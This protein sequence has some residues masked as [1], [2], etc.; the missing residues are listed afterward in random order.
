MQPI[1]NVYFD[2][3]ATTPLKE[4]VVVV[5]HKALLEDYGNPSSTH[6]FGRKVKSKI[7]QARKNIAHYLNADASEIIFTSGATE[8]DNL[9]LRS[10]VV[11]LNVQHI[12][13][14]K[15]E[16]HA[17]LH[18]IE[19]LVAKVQVTAHFL[20]V[21]SKGEP[22][23]NQLEDLLKNLEG[24]KLVS[25][26]YVNNEI[27]N[28]LD[29]E[30]VAG[31]CKNYGALFHSDTVQA[32]GHQPLDL[33]K[34]S[35]DFIVAAAH[36]FHG[37][38]GVGFVFVRKGHSLKALIGG[39][40]QEKGLRAGTEAT[41]NILGMEKALQLAY[42][43]FDAEKEYVLGIKKYFVESIKRVIPVVK[44]NGNSAHY[45]KSNFNIVNFSLPLSK[46]TSDL[47]MFQ[48]DLKGIAC[49][50]GSACQSGASKGSHVLSEILTEE[51]SAY[52]AL[53]FSF[54][55]FNTKEEVDFVIDQLKGFFKNT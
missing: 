16:H 13:S 32:I 55:V 12:I 39:G 53:R 43:H 27:G 28:V 24:K 37:P 46:P 25:L 47:L 40:A 5:M 45:E 34:H 31:M 18:T 11:D 1:K 10:A 21:N 38:K 7:E 23:L 29:F 6:S 51:E 44:F 8:S 22:D 9:V 54:S 52:P 41:H 33:K 50:Q 20:E 36:K 35:V 17:V 48:L 19:E 4:E 14:T 49:S 3:A 2:N 30:K 42:D 26:M 15:I